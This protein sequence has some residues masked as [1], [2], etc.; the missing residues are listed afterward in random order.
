MTKSTP[1]PNRNR[2]KLAAPLVVL[3][4]LLP[5]ASRAERALSLRD[6]IAI[7]LGESPKLQASRFDLLAAGEEIRAA[8]ASL[9]PNVTGS[10]TGEE[11]S[12]SPT[13]KFGI[14]N[15][16]SPSGVGINNTKEVSSAGIGIFGGKVEYP[17]F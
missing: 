11:F 2:L 8:Q 13:G 3:L 7:A 6:C 9:W 14:V 4:L 16:T 10:V 17:L 5:Q 1:R 15:F 12:G